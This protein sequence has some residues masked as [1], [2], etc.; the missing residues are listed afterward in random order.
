MSTSH[1][2]PDVG[3]SL[4][5]ELGAAIAQATGAAWQAGRIA[6]ERG[7]L[8][9]SVAPIGLLLEIRKDGEAKAYRKIGGFAFAYRS[10]EGQTFAA[11][12]LHLLDQSIHALA[13]VLVRSGFDLERDVL[14]LEQRDDGFPTPYHVAHL[15]EEVALPPSVIEQY[16]KDGHVLVRRAINPDVVRAAVPLINGALERAWPHRL[17]PV[18]E[19]TDAYS[20]GFTQI[21]GLGATDPVLR[22]FSNMR[23]IMRMCAD[24]MGVSGV[25]LFCEDWLIK[26]PGARITPWHQDAAVFPLDAEATITAWI[27]LRDIA[28]GEGLLRFVR[29]AH[30]LG[31]GTVEGIN[32]ESEAAYEQIIRDHGLTIDELPPVFVGDVSFHD[33]RSIHGAFG[34]SGEEHRAVLALHC[35]A[36]GATI[37]HHPTA[38]MRET[39]AGAAPSLSAG[40]VA[41]SDAWPLVFGAK[42]AGPARVALV[43][44]NKAPVT[45]HAIVLPEGEAKSI[46][47]ERGLLRIE[48]LADG[49]PTPTQYVSSGLVEAHGHISYPH[50]REDPASELRWMNPRR[51]DYAETGVTLIRD[52][53]ATDD[54]ICKLLD[55]PGL[56]RVH[57]TGLMVVRSDDWPLVRTEPEDLV[58][59]CVERVQRGAR[60]VKVFTDFSDDYRGRIDPG[61]TE[62]DEVMYPVDLLRE[63]VDAV[64]ALGARL[65]AHCFTQAGTRVSV[66]AGVDTLEHGW[67]V[68]EELLELMLE[69]GTAWAPLLCIARP[70]WEV[71]VRDGHRDRQAWLRR[72]MVELRRMLPLAERRGVTLLA[73]TDQFPAITVADEV[74][75]MHSMGLTKLGALAAGTWGA[76]AYLGEQGLRTGAP[77]DLVVY[78]R[79]PREDLSA[80]LEFEVV[81]LGGKVVQRSFAHTRP[82]FEPFV[83]PD[84]G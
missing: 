74:V 14:S 61:F 71:A 48:P 41:R 13:E 78:P 29:A 32:D 67:G 84:E 58:R 37:K 22:V 55:T 3:E 76:R 53:G 20:Q 31:L 6:Q 80:L 42:A 43:G 7:L 83:C 66:Q 51:L 35:F 82:S 63:A 56:P 10:A 68:D 17:P 77:A 27:P 70:M 2:Q 1:R 26:E 69:R 65:G 4:V 54:A 8:R 45:L 21:T 38:A 81:M 40:D 72:T 30:H 64:H 79:D 39:L 19:R 57:A 16:R 34:N 46:T 28:E 23:R 75:Q 25:R 52:M 62:H 15:Y 24:L 11:Q 44:A 12:T 59:T 18:E 73:G 9:V 33:G 50:T 60:W 5:E 36:D 49:E 47:I